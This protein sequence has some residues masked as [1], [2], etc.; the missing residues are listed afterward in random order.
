MREKMWEGG[1][2]GTEE[3]N[4]EA[5]VGRPRFLLRRGGEGFSEGGAQAAFSERRTPSSAR[6][7]S[8]S[9]RTMRA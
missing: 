8:G 9:S 7:K 1:G 6:S 4:G 2:R 3:E 5:G